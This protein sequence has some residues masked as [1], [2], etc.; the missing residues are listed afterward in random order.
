M[1]PKLFILLLII[2]LISAWYFFVSPISD[3]I[4]MLK[5]EIV[6]EEKIIISKKTEIEKMKAFEEQL[7]D[8]KKEKERME[9]AL[10]SEPNIEELMVEFE[11]LVIKSG[12]ALNKIVIAPAKKSVRQRSEEEDS[13]EI[14][15]AD[16]VIVNLSVSGSYDALKRLL[17]LSQKDLRLMDIQRI[18]FSTRTN[19]EDEGI[20]IYDFAIDIQTY[21]Y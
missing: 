8:L 17:L 4:D 5:E 11:A 9:T 19:K 10:P 14:Y 1:N 6:S 20:L 16:R 3:R 13:K 7:Q 15:Q 12:M 18:G 2:V 21:Y